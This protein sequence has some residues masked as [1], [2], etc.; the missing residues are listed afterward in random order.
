MAFRTRCGSNI[1]TPLGDVP[2]VV[3]AIFA[4]V[5]LFLLVLAVWPWYERLMLRRRIRNLPPPPI[6]KEIEIELKLPRRHPGDNPP[7]P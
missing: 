5:V 3:A 1:P 2:V 4:L 6:K 7:G